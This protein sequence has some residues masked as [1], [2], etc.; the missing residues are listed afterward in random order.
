VSFLEDGFLVQGKL[1]MKWMNCNKY[2]IGQGCFCFPS[3][4]VFFFLTK[5]TTS[6][7]WADEHEIQCLWRVCKVDLM[8]LSDDGEING[9]YQL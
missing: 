2:R 1:V 6:D 7:A 3:S 4:P 8:L 5:L 9:A